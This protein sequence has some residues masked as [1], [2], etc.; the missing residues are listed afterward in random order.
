MGPVLSLLWAI[1]A[2]PHFDFYTLFYVLAFT[3]NLGMLIW[4]GHRR[5]YPLRSWLVLLAVTTLMFIIGTKLLAF[6]GAEWRALLYSGHWP[7]SEARTVLGGALTG[8]LTVLLLRRPFGFSWH[9]FDAFTLPMCAALMV[10]CVGCLLTGC[11][12]GELTHSSWGV[13]YPPDTQP[14]LWQVSQGLLSVGAQHSLPVHPTQLYTLL[15]CAAVGGVLLLTRNRIWPGGSRRLLHMGLL[16]AARFLIEFWRNPAGEQVGAAEHMHG[17]LVLKQLQWALLLLAPLFLAGWAFL[18]RCPAQPERVPG[19]SPV[20]NLLGVAGMLLLTAWLGQWA[21]TLPEVLVVK[22][23]LLAVVLLEGGALLWSAPQAERP[24]RVSVPLGLACC[25]FLLTSQTPADSAQATRKSYY[26]VV[27]AWSQGSFQRQQNTYGGGCGGNSA[28]LPYQHDYTTGS[29]DISKT[30]MPGY[31]ASGSHKAEKTFGLRLHLGSD[32]QVPL[33]D[34]SLQIS[35]GKK[36]TS[37]YGLNPYMQADRRYFGMGLGLM[38]GN[39]GYHEKEYGDEISLVEIQGTLRLGQ[40]Q[41]VYAQADY[42]FLGYG[43]ANPQHRLGVG[44]G[45]GGTRWGLLVGGA[46]AKP[47]KLLPGASGWSGFAEARGQLAPH[48]GV[49]AFALFGNESQRQVGIQVSRRL[50][51]KSR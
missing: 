3:L 5:G 27:A 4:E 16:L 23:L 20:R 26:T 51:E 15:A 50:G 41:S 17:G 34:D 36:R 12:F 1:P 37:L 47:Y 21:L 38:F 49:N 18:I 33:F 11:C 40:R 35:S 8:T 9:V 13:T 14:Y 19:N 39:L 10:Q 44:T 22:A 43:P 24:Y 32:Q 45:F 6:S 7:A 31:D 46:R 28:L 30:I 48:W 25:L 42:N 2:N 29:L